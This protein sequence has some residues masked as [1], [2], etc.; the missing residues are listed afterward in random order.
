MLW[1]FERSL[2]TM[3]V[4]GVLCHRIRAIIENN[5]F[6]K[7]L[8]NEF[9]PKMDEI[10]W[11]WCK[12]GTMKMKD[13]KGRSSSTYWKELCVAVSSCRLGDKIEGERGS[14]E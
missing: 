8:E 14:G 13:K 10:F 7:S 4:L 3:S 12:E 6:G 9:V 5:R 1:A 11:P 2:T